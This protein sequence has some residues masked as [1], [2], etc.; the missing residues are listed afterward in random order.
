[1]VPVCREH[2]PVDWTDV[3][4]YEACGFWI[5][6]ASRDECEAALRAKGLLSSSGSR[7][8]WASVRRLA[9]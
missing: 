8:H 1:M 2:D 6:V 4:S 9:R 7:R 3:S 5:G